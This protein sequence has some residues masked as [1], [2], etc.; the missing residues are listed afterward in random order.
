MLDARFGSKAD[1]GGRPRHVR[2]P[3][4]ADVN[5]RDRHVRFVPKAN[6]GS[7]FSHNVRKTKHLR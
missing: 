3:L 5:E 4:K 2:L 7:E 1:I 6:I